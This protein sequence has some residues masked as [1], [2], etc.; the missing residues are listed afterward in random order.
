MYER[1]RQLTENSSIAHRALG[2]N[3]QRS[4]SIGLILLYCTKKPDTVAG[5]CRSRVERKA[6]EVELAGLRQQGCFEPA[7]YVDLSALN[8]LWKLVRRDKHKFVHV[9]S[10]SADPEATCTTAKA[11]GGTMRRSSKSAKTP[12]KTSG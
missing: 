3:R 6:R 2:Q 12:A 5:N 1:D 7:V 8:Y 4:A 9:G 10:V 11:K